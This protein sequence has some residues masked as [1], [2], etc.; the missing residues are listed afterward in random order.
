MVSSGLDGLR[1]R[2]ERAEDHGCDG[3]KQCD[4]DQYF[5]QR[6]TRLAFKR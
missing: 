3:A 1:G 2:K 6:K 5:D 4:G